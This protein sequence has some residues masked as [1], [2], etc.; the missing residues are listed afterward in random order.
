MTYHDLGYFS[1]FA[2]EI[3]EENQIPEKFSFIE[4]IKKS[5]K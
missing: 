4:F 3:Y 5:K 2:N 1:L